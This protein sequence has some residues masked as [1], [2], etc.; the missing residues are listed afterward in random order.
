MPRSDDATEGAGAGLRAR[1]GG[2]VVDMVI[3]SAVAMVMV[4]IAGGQLLLVTRG[5]TRNASDPTLYAF[6]GI[7]GL[8]TPLAWTL[9][10]LLVLLTR[11]Q[12]GGQ[13]V[14]GLR[15]ARADGGAPGARALLAWWFCLNPLLFSWPMALVTGLPAA[16]AASLLLQRATLAVFL[17]FVTLCV[18][19]PI[20]ALAAASTDARRRGLH[21]RIAGTVVVPAG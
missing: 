8:G 1:V 6:L 14:A 9:L 3:F 2:Y 21:D 16:G 17:T 7:I 18:A 15:I 11:R 5:A 20:V 4:V 12:T 13:Y 19:A 10:N